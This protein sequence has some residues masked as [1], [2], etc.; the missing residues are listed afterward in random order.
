MPGN[1]PGSLAFLAVFLT[2]SCGPPGRSPSQA[3]QSS[4]CHRNLGLKPKGSEQPCLHQFVVVV[5]VVHNM[6]LCVVRS[7]F[8]QANIVLNG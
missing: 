7:A 1:L 8:L 5:V 6:R 4:G 2:F 3:G